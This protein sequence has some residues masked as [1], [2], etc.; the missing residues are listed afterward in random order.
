MRTSK[1]FTLIE[2]LIALLFF[3]MI[4]NFSIVILANFTETDMTTYQRQNV[5]GILQLRQ[6]LALSEN[7]EIIENKL[8]MLYNSNT[9]CFYEQSDRLIKTPGTEIYLINVSSISFTMNEKNVEITFNEGQGL[10][11]RVIAYQK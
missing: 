1:G 7:I 2:L 11:K 10:I 6:F 4:L 5:I 8:C 9:C 3:P